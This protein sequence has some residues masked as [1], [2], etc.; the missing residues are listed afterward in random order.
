MR[1]AP[2]TGLPLAALVPLARQ[3]SIERRTVWLGEDCRT[4]SFEY[5]RVETQWKQPF[6][7][8]LCHF[9]NG[10]RRRGR[11]VVCSLVPR[12]IVSRPTTVAFP[13]DARTLSPATRFNRPLQ[14]ADGLNRKSKIRPAH[15]F[16]FPRQSL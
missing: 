13:F 3:G 10:E 1:S 4:R 2:E 11:C 9:R 12:A 5:R 15:R 14:N 7:H 16:D 6:A 8:C